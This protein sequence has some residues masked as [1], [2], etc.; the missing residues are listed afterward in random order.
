MVGM[1]RKKKKGYE[2]AVMVQE[3]ILMFLRAEMAWGFLT[4]NLLALSYL[5]S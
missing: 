3:K 1:G 4:V 5:I 2:K